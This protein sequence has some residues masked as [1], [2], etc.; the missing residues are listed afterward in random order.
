MINV[1]KVWLV[2]FAIIVVLISSTC[3]APSSD[4]TT[5]PIGSVHVD[6][7]NPC[8][9]A[10]APAQWNH[11]VVLIFENKTY[12]QVVGVAPY[13]TSLVNK[14]GTYNDWK[15]AD[16]KVD[17]SRDGNYRSKP[18]YA[19]LTNG[20]SPSAHGLLDDSYETK[21]QVDNIYHQLLVAGK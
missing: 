7:S 1:K 14:C 13:I 6:A 19:T 8:I 15:D 17:G 18:S 21:T 20:L 10:R 3:G 16:Y 5:T 9:G 11:I 2:S 12:D 4:P